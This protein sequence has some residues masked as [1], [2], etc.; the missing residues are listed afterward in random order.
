[1]VKHA[2]REEPNEGFKE[3]LCSIEID[4]AIKQAGKK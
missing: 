1:M 3:L 2:S 4:E